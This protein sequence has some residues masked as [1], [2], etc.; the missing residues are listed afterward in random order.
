MHSLDKLEKRQIKLAAQQTRAAQASLDSISTGP[1]DHILKNPSVIDCAC[2][3][4]GDAYS[5]TYVERLYNMLSRHIT[6]DIRLHVYTE[7]DRPVPEPM[8]RHDLLPWHITRARRA[9]WYKMQMFNPEYHAGPLLYFDLDTVIVGNID[10]IWQQP[11][12]YFWGVRDFKY[13]WRPTHTGI[14]SSVMWW[15]TR[16][17]Q[18]V[19]ETFQAQ[20]L[21]T[22]MRK[23]H[24]DQDYIGAVIAQDQR[25]FLDSNSIVSWRWQCQDGGFDFRRRRGHTPGTG[26][27]I[28][29]SASVLV[30]HGS[31]KPDKI[32][33]VQVLQHWR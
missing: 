24:G 25:R 26:T 15:D 29:E 17:H 19:W 16:Q 13:L 33:D 9:W 5:W 22:V 8:I 32:T 20:D 10:W 6:P 14:N 28:P 12:Q 4:H 27:Q 11:L 23:Y 3:I 7:A 31:P 2:V 18:Q 1:T 30:F 21:V